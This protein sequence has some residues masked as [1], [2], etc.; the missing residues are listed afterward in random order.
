M[1]N[2]PPVIDSVTPAGPITANVGDKVTLTVVAH[3]AD[4]HTG[5]VQLVVNDGESDSQPVTVPIQWV[6]GLTLVVTTD[7]GKPVTVNGMTAVVG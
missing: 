2:T 3:D 7:D 1:A 5:N 4:T 6:D